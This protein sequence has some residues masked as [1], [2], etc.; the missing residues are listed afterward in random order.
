MLETLKLHN[1][2]FQNAFYHNQRLN[3]ARRELFGCTDEIDIESL[4]SIPDDIG[5]GIYKCSVVYHSNIVD[6]IFQPYKKRDIKKLRLIVADK[7]DYSYKY[8][9]RSTLNMYLQQKGECDEVLFVRN[10][11]ITDTTFTNIVFFDGAK[12]VTPSTPL[13]RGTKREQLLKE[14]KITEA[15]IKITDL[16]LYEKAGLINCMLDLGDS[17]VDLKDILF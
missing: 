15:P 17:L 9:D 3:K 12:W 4:V 7:L 10:K 2:R 8:A 1:R 6:T 14:G 11:M 16:N 5:D 13:L